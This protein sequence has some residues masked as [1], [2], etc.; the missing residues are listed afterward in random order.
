[1]HLVSTMLECYGSS[2]SADL[3]GPN[4]RLSRTLRWLRCWVGMT[5]AFAMLLLIGQRIYAEWAT[6]Q[7]I[8]S[9]IRPGWFLAVIGVIAL[10]TTLLGWNWISILA[11]RGIQ[12][13]WPSALAFYLL[14]N[15]AR[16]LPGEIWHF[17]G[18][19]TRLAEQGYK[20]RSEVE[21]LILEQTMVLASAGAIGF[22]LLGLADHTALMGVQRSRWYCW[23]E[24]R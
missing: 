10:S 3:L 13:Y 22:S 16:Y 7:T 8:V 9:Q 2:Y 5:L 6:I 19:T 4:G 21:S 12:V 15:L 1:M 14:T 17:A 18:R 20:L 11:S 24:L 23:P